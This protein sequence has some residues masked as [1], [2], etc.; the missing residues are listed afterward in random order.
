MMRCEAKHKWPAQYIIYMMKA[1]LIPVNWGR[2]GQVCDA[3]QHRERGLRESRGL[4]LA[5]RAPRVCR[6]A[7]TNA[8][9]NAARNVFLNLAGSASRATV[10]FGA[11]VYLFRGDPLPAGCGEFQW[12]AALDVTTAG[13]TKATAASGSQAK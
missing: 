13:S 10:A 5:S 6:C 9:R 7:L 1:T 2:A 11:S 4:R 12:K 8:T 3:R